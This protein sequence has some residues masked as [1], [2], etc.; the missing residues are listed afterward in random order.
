MLHVC[1]FTDNTIFTVPKLSEIYK[2]FNISPKIT[3][4]QENIKVT[5]VQEKTKE[6]ISFV[7][8]FLRDKRMN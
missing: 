7:I 5:N 6:G 8:N 4:T 2:F 3:D 1:T